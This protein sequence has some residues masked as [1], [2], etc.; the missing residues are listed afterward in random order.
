MIFTEQKNYCP[1]I[2]YCTETLIPNALGAYVAYCSIGLFRLIAQ[3]SS[4]KNSSEKNN[5]E[6]QSSRNQ[7]Q[8]SSRDLK[9]KAINLIS[10][11]SELV[12]GQATAVKAISDAVCLHITGLGDPNKPAANLLFV[13]PTGVG[14]TEMAKAIASEFFGNPSSILSINAPEY[15]HQTDVHRL[16]GATPGYAGYGDGG[17]LTNFVK[18]N[19]YSVILVDEV[20]KGH[21][22]IMDLFLKIMDEGQI[23]DTQG[24]RIDFTNTII[25]FTSNAGAAENRIDDAIKK[26]F[27]PE[28]LGRLNAVVQFNSMSKEMSN[29]IVDLEIAKIAK[30]ALSKGITLC[31]SDS[32]LE[33]LYDL[34]LKT[35]SGK[36]AREIKGLISNYLTSPLSREIL[37]SQAKN[38]LL[39][40]A[41]NNLSIT[42]RD[43]ILS[44]SELAIKV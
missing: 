27:R 12:I 44:D 24:N 2:S 39:E 42:L 23:D 17:L 30:R 25:V 29:R 1:F 20:E 26:V 6:Q 19:P 4:E 15:T 22:Q 11:L 5:Q 36:G 7:E 16:I 33:H 18:N 3:Y 41:E 43:P 31:F 34:A 8:Q 21:T 13:G 14:K 40:V 35:S 9:S 32:L 38:Y 10:S 28:F 37:T